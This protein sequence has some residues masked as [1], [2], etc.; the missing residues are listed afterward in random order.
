MKCI[1]LI[2]FSGFIQVI[3][4]VRKFY[5]KNYY[6]SMHKLFYTIYLL[7]EYR[8]NPNNYSKLELIVAIFV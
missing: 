4:S 7:E 3:S 1:H 8:L 6:F 5:T 2:R